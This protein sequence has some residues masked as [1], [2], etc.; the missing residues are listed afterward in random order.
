MPAKFRMFELRDFMRRVPQCVT[1]VTT[2]A[3]GVPHGM[4]VSSFTSVSLDPPTILIILEKSTQTCKTVLASRSFCVNLLSEK[5]SFVSDVFAY[6][7]HEERFEKIQ[8]HVESGKYP[9]IDGAIGALF[10]EVKESVEASTHNVILAI[11]K[12]VKIFSNDQP[13]I[14]LQRQYHRPVK[15]TATA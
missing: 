11:V 9:I 3:N 2:V 7:P 14:Y 15:V 4:T 8:Y 12:E 5:Q 13:L 1:V 10:C 6:V